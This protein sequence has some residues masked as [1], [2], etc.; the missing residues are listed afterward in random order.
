[1]M[2]C[3]T[4]S[5]RTGRPPH[6]LGEIEIAPLAF[7]RGRTLAHCFAILDEAQNTTPRR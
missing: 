2:H 3:T 7:M 4:C 1:M 6:R 5:R